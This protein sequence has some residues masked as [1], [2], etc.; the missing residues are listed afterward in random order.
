[1]DGWM[2]GRR[3]HT[4]LHHIHPFLL[5]LA[6]PQPHS[7]VEAGRGQQARGQEGEG[8]GGAGLVAPVRLQD[9]E[10]V[11]GGAVF[12]YVEGCVLGGRKGV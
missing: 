5:Y 1:M 6:I 11:G 7:A 3:G 12:I 2:G 10:R 8:E 4:P 9:P